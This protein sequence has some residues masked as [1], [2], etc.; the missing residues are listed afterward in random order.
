MDYETSKTV[1]GML[2]TPPPHYVAVI[3]VNGYV[4]HKKWL[5]FSQVSK[6]RLRKLAQ[7]LRALVLSEDLDSWVWFPAPTLWLT[8]ILSP[9]RCDILIWPLWTLQAHG[10]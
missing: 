8:T 1:R 5:N 9:K 4:A 7:Q 3:M 2:I 6:V 10:T